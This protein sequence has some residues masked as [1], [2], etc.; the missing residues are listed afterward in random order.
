MIWWGPKKTTGNDGLNPHSPIAPGTR[1]KFTRRSR[2]LAG[3]VFRI[4]ERRDNLLTM[5][6]GLGLDGNAPSTE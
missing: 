6:D 2:Y 1:N 4:Y 5:A 3:K